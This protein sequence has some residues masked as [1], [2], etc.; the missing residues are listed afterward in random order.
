MRY[1][2]ENMKTLN[3]ELLKKY[4][5]ATRKQAEEEAKPVEVKPEPVPIQNPLDLNMSIVIKDNPEAEGVLV[6]K[7][8]IPDF[9]KVLTAAS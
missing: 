9:E 5:E 4:E 3:L 8:T 2:N 1:E 7:R 6:D